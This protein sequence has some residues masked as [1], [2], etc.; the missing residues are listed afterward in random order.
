[1]SNKKYILFI[2]NDSKMQEMHLNWKHFISIFLVIF[3]L[4]SI[5]VF[6]L[7]K[8]FSKFHYQEKIAKVY[9]ENDNLE[10][11]INLMQEKVSELNKTIKNIKEKDNAIRLY[12]NLPENDIN[13]DELGTGG[14]VDRKLYVGD[15]IS[16]RATKLTNVD[17]SLTQISKELQS[18]LISYENLTEILKRKKQKLDATPTIVPLK[19]NAYISSPYGKRVDP[20][21]GRI[22]MHDG[23]DFATRSGTPIYATADGKVKYAKYIGGYGYTIKINHGFGYSTIYGHMSK[24]K[25]KKYQSVKRGDLIGYVGNTG[26]STGP[27]LHYE[28]RYNNNPVNPI[29][30][31]WIRKKL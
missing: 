26:R 31:M 20:F 7:S 17:K 9:K 18:E 15:E 19:N 10:L 6:G 16:K 3:V 27:H 23:I 2:E 12:S 24:M 8:I 5:S 14:R 29:K 21:T 13:I 4:F 1:M 28:I 30:Y 11:S 22:G 25:A